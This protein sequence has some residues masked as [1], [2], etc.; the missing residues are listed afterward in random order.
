MLIAHQS[1]GRRAGDTD[2]G[3]FRFRIVSDVAGRLFLFAVWCR[4]KLTLAAMDF[5][6]GAVEHD[7]RWCL[8]PCLP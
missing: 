7:F 8:A 4:S 1:L 5:D 3:A 2:D 6:F